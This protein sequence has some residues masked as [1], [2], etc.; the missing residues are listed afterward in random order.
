VSTKRVKNRAPVSAGSVVIVQ[1]EM[2]GSL[3]IW[4]ARRDESAPPRARC[5]GCECAPNARR[6]ANT[7]A[8]CGLGHPLMAVPGPVTSAMCE[9]RHAPLR[10]AVD[11]AVLSRP[12]RTCLESL[13]FLGV[14][15]ATIV[16]SGVRASPAD[17][18]RA[19]IDALDPA[20]RRVF[21]A[22]QSR[23]FASPASLSVRAGVPGLEVVRALP[24]LTLN[25]LVETVDGGYRARGGRESDGSQAW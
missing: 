22:L 20:A 10:R 15:C 3:R 7:A 25:G 24:V 13:G 23:W 14:L 18:R 5:A 19:A 17:V 8:H 16:T 2:A 11:P 9:G 1:P 6:A 12:R 4:I 21:E